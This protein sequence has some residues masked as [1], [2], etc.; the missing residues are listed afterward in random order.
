MRDK[1]NHGTM[2]QLTPHM[3]VPEYKIPRER[4]RYNRTL[5]KRGDGQ[6]DKRNMGKT[7]VS[8]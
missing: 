2:G 8:T 3:D 4:Q 1:T 6:T 7:S 5:Q